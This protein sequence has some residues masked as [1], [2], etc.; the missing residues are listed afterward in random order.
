MTETE[1][2]GG[3][4]ETTPTIGET[5]FNADG[6][7]I[8]TVSGRTGSGF[9]VGADGGSGGGRSTSGEFGEAYL[10]WRCSE[11]GEMGPIESLPERCPNCRAE[12]ESLYYSTED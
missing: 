1:P 7:P 11:C 5:V 6:E 12:R 8:G 2:A 9:V 3:E 4:A 10:M